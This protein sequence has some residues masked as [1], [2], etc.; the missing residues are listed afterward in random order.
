MRI[1][2]LHPAATEIVYLLGLWDQLVGVSADSSWPAA[3]AELP[4]VSASQLDLKGLPSSEIHRA[5][6]DRAA[7]HQ[8]R[9]LYH[10]DQELLRSL[11]PELIL[12][13]ELCDVCALPAGALA[14]VLQSLGYAPRVLSLNPET[15]D[16]VLNDVL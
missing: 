15:L 3:A 5:V 4:Q 14:P 7:S 2:S 13:Q 8:G 1:L 6:A 11:R 9:S 12:S 16:D 10:L